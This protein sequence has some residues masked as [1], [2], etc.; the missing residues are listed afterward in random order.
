MGD[1]DRAQ[2][3]NVGYDKAMAAARNHQVGVAFPRF[4]EPGSTLSDFNDLHAKEGL[5]AVQA[6][7]EKAIGLSMEQSREQAALTL[8]AARPPIAERAAPSLATEE[9]IVPTSP[10]RTAVTTEPL[11]VEPAAAALPRH[12]VGD[13]IGW[14]NQNAQA[15]RD[16]SDRMGVTAQIEEA[17]AKGLT[18]GQVRVDLS[19]ANKLD[20]VPVEEQPSFLV[21]VQA[22][23]GI[24]SRGTED[25]QSE[26]AAW[27]NERAKRMAVADRAADVSISAPD[28]K[29]CP[30][31]CLGLSRQ[32]E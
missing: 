18:A 8:T 4:Q 29:S 11:V 21:N 19:S 12:A 22:T 6:Q 27:Q 32:A 14:L 20:K 31:R 3:P 15:D 7:V 10:S 28:R 30:A 16:R 2:L 24:P 17:F 13:P 26:F 9:T 25:G 5:R 1:D 23:L